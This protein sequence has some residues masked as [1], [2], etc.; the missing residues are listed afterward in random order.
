MTHDI[1]MTDDN[2]MIPMIMSYPGC[3]RGLKINPTVSSLDLMPTILD[4]LGIQVDEA[5][6]AKWVGKSLVPLLEGEHDDQFHGRKIRTDAR[7]MGQ[8]DRVSA[9]RDDRYKYVYHHDTGVEEF[10]DVTE[11]RIDEENIAN[12]KDEEIQSAL[13][14][15]RVAFS[16]SE[17]SGRE[18]Q[19]D[20][21]TYRLKQQL[22]KIRRISGS[23][24][25]LRVL[26]LSTAQLAFVESI[27]KSLKV[28]FSGSEISAVVRSSFEEIPRTVS[29]FSNLLRFTSESKSYE[30]AYGDIDS[31]RD[32]VN[33]GVDLVILTYDSTVNEE[34]EKLR[35][36]SKKVRS[37]KTVMIDLNMTVSIRKGQAQRY[38]RTLW[39]NRKF[40]IDEPQLIVSEVAKVIR[41]LNRKK[42]EVN[43]L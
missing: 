19:V 12:S 1:F 32:L 17:R 33:D 4:L 28:V 38:L 15:F 22:G 6:R 31:F 42:S 41:V 9:L 18:F 3:E 30:I 39:A 21:A 5:V 34:F 8:S 2:I 7:F 23:K 10:V 20:Y 43:S 14:D 29:I 27:A 24:A 25:G 11:F 40:Y 35:Q 36:F 37:S 26:I 13:E 16:E